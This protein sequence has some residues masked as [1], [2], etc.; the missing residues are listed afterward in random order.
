MSTEVV[1]KKDPFGVVIREP[2][3]GLDLGRRDFIKL[4]V[5][6]DP[7]TGS[8]TPDESEVIDLYEL[9][10]T[11]RDQ[12]GMELAQ[13]LIKNGLAMPGDFAD[14][15]QHSGDV[16]A[17]VFES[18]QAAANAAIAAQQKT[19]S[20]LQE[21]GLNPSALQ[22]NEEQLSAIVSK[23]IAEKFPQLIKQQ[24]TPSNAE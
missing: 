20:M 7:K 13:K 4:K 11:Y 1:I 24:E 21:L 23:T 16:S 9:T 8:T 22:L 3:P 5:K 6:F 18:V 17:P 10:Q 12:C 2:D 19:E 15:G 14:D